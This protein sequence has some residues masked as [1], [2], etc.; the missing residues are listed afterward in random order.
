MFT[1]DCTHSSR[2]AIFAAGVMTRATDQKKY[3]EFDVT[4]PF[5]ESILL[6][7]KSV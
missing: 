1:R 5:R 4:T 6:S 7:E 2:Y 3:S